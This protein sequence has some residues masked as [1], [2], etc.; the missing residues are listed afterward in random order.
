LNNDQITMLLSILYDPDSIQLV[1][2]NIESGDPNGIAYAIE[3]MDLFIDPDL[4]PKL[5]PLYDDIPDSEETGVIADLFPTR[6]LQ[7]RCR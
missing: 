7:L 2:E 4:K 1:R 5:F 3:L 6:E